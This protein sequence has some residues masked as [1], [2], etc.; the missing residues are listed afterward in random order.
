MVQLKVLL[1][2]MDPENW[3]KGCCF[4]YFVVCFVVS[5]LI[6][7]RTSA[8]TEPNSTVRSSFNFYKGNNPLITGHIRGF[9]RYRRQ[10]LC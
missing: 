9:I 6:W 2:A 1:L 4:G 8:A 5:L 10:T 7:G 3:G